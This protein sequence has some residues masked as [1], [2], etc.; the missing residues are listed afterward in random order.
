VEEKKK[1]FPWK[2]VAIVVVIIL[3]VVAMSP[4]FWMNILA[5]SL[6]EY[7][8]T[9]ESEDYSKIIVVLREKYWQDYVDEK[10]TARDFRL[11]SIE[12]I[13]YINEHGEKVVYGEEG[14]ITLYLKTN[15]KEELKKAV[16]RVSLLKFV[17]M[18]YQG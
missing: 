15:T 8:F 2:K 10:F 4:L 16:A 13:A 9:Y 12:T 7:V 3:L 5:E 14:K 17:L 11:K 6:S 1:V 18:A